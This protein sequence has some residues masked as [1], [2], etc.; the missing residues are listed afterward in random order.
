MNLAFSLPRSEKEAAMIPRRLI[1]E[2][3]EELA[4]LPYVS[5]N[6]KNMASR[7]NPYRRAAARISRKIRP[8]VKGR[9]RKGALVD[10]P[11][12]SALTAA[13]EAAAR[14]THPLISQADAIIAYNYFSTLEQRL[15]IGY[16][17][18]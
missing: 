15:G 14:S 11:P 16:R 12:E 18:V 9:K 7:P 1:A 8:P 2:L 3:D 13:L 17:L 5:A 6:A 10:H 4:R